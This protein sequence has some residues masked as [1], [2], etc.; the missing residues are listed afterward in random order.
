MEIAYVSA[1]SGKIE[2]SRCEIFGKL[3]YLG[4]I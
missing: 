3:A 2:E 4:C 1:I